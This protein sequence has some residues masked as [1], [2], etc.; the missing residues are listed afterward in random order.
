MKKCKGR[1][2]TSVGHEHRMSKSD[3]ERDVWL[4]TYQLRTTEHILSVFDCVGQKPRSSFDNLL[5]SFF[6][7][8]HCGNAQ[9]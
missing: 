3:Q 7:P 9:A 5:L 6:Y 1:H 8:F 2:R 4:R